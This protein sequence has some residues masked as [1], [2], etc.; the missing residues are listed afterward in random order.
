MALLQ[1]FRSVPREHLPLPGQ[2][3]VSA[4]G[5]T[6]SRHIKQL[7]KL[8]LGDIAINVFRETTVA[9]KF[10]LRIIT[11]I[12]PKRPPRKFSYLVT[13]HTKCSNIIS[14]RPQNELSY[15]LKRAVVQ[16]GS[17]IKNQGRH[18][19]RGQ[20]ALVIDPCG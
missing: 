18:E 14:S 4:K 16:G 1:Y 9:R 5:L 3:L 13:N 11:A 10:N 6:L 8:N 12:Q 2:S 15:Y 17:V 19:V 7:K 20:L